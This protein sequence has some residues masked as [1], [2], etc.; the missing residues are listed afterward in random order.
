MLQWKCYSENVAVE[1]VCKEL[2][3]N[4][5]PKFNKRTATIKIMTI[6]R[7]VMHV[8]DK[9]KIQDWYLTVV[10]PNSSATSNNCA[11]GYMERYPIIERFSAIYYR[12]V[13]HQNFIGI[14][15]E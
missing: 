7:I 8:E 12:N 9:S 5:M 1:M 13:L 3:Y 10:F 14:S 6:D 4:S 11:P 2:N 15:D